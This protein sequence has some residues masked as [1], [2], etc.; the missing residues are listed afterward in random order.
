MMRK[1]RP[2]QPITLALHDMKRFLSFLGLVVVAAVGT[3]LLIPY[4]VSVE[5]IREAVA[6]QLEAATGREVT[7]SGPA[8]LSVLPSL[9]V[10]VSGVTIAN[11]SGLGPEPFA[12]MDG[13]SAS[14]QILPLLTGQIR[15]DRLVMVRPRFNLALDEAGRANWHVG[16][17]QPADRRAAPAGAAQEG[18]GRTVSIDEFLVRDGQIVY[19]DLRSGAR[20]QASSINATVNWPAPGTA[21]TAA[22]SLVWRGEVVNFR[23]RSADAAALA[24]GGR[25]ETAIALETNRGSVELT[26]MISTAVDFAVDGQ[27]SLRTPSLRALARWFDLDLPVAGGMNELTLRSKFLAGGPKLSFSSAT[28]SLDGNAAEGAIIVRLGAPRPLVQATLAL[29]TLNLNPYLPP[30]ASPRA[31][32]RAAEQAPAQ[33]WS[34]QPF[35]LSG[36]T[37]IDADVRLSA[38]R[39]AARTLPLGGGALTVTL[40]DGML[41]GQIAQLKAYDGEIGATLVIDGSRTTPLISL[42]ASAQKVQ[43][44][45][46]LRDIAGFDRLRAT[47]DVAVNLSTSGRSEQVLVQRLAGTAQLSTGAG[48]ITGIDLGVMIAGLRRQPLEGWKTDAAR[49]TPF[50]RLQASFAVEQGIARNDDLELSG[51]SLAVNGGGTI[52]LPRQSVD[53]RVTAALQEAPPAT[54][55]APRV[56][57]RLPVIVRGPWRAPAFY[58]DPVGLIDSVPG[59]RQAVD[60]AAD[61][62]GR[63]DVRGAADALKKNGINNLLDALGGRKEKNR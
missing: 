5:T 54:G 63:G 6:D 17:L 45:P 13:L 20:Q 59:A 53:Y 36:L 14:L 26:G 27:I 38:N 18:G 46:L 61:A 47:G 50:D 40:K 62:L 22:G 43:L 19:V 39:I 1:S 29:A 60:D 9:K 44:Q 35:D 58:P 49:Q 57:V 25:S 30:P 28:L 7:F 8:S 37:T 42:N 16:R 12:A 2:A 33:G 56:L 10:Q 15:F 32:E 31:Q 41:T 48:A 21:M 4:V 3:F 34:A 51:R 11:A 24:T 52:D 55:N 23:V